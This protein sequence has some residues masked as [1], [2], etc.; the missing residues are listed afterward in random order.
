MFVPF[1]LELEKARKEVDA[2]KSQS[3]GLTKE[4]DRLLE[5]H[6]KLEVGLSILCG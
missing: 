3:E 6:S 1:V 4:Y 5:E 2:M